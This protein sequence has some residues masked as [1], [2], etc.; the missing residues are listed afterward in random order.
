MSV[1]LS[2]NFRSELKMFLLCLLKRVHISDHISGNL[3]K[4]VSCLKKIRAT[5]VRI[6]LP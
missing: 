5:V 6:L 4:E 3:L 2:V 1:G